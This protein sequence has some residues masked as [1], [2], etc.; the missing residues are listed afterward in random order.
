MKVI[1]KEHARE[2]G[3]RRYFTGVPCRHGHLC[4]R[5]ISSYIC[6]ECNRLRQRKD[7][8]VE[9]REYPPASLDELISVARRFKGTVQTIKPIPEAQRKRVIFA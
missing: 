2:L 9:K 5:L 1:T 4:E 6:V 7:F 8:H 3:L